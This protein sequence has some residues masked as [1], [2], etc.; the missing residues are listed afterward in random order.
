M[1]NERN[2]CILLAMV[3]TGMAFRACLWLCK[4]ACAQVPL[5]TRFLQNVGLAGS[6]NCDIYR[7]S[8]M[9]IFIFGIEDD[10]HITC[11]DNIKKLLFLVNFVVL[12][13][14]EQGGKLN[15]R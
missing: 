7:A 6:Y 13:L 2:T 10:G 4:V 15:I 8:H 3:N 1:I 9:S 11:S 5:L 14:L 12:P